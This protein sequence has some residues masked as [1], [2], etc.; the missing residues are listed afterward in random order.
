MNRRS[1][2]ASILALLCF[3][4]K[5]PEPEKVYTIADIT[6]VNPNAM[7]SC[8]TGRKSATEIWGACRMGKVTP[9]NLEIPFEVDPIFLDLN[10]SPWRDLV[11]NYP[12]KS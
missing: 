4:R 9:S 2:F 6:G 1:F 12:R 10:E 5:R 7:G 3:W 8:G 11:K